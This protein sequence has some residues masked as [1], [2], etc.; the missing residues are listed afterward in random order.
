MS[1]ESNTL[2]SFALTLEFFALH[3]RGQQSRAYTPEG[4]A[5]CLSSLIPQTPLR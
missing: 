5:A 4:A 2:D 3:R 1:V